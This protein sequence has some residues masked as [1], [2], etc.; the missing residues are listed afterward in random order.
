M[1]ETV[2]VL[3]LHLPGNKQLT[4]TKLSSFFLSVCPFVTL[5]KHPYCGFNAQ[6]GA[7][8]LLARGHVQYP[9]MCQPIQLSVRSRLSRGAPHCCFL[10]PYNIYMH[11][12]SLSFRSVAPSSDR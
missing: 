6:R 1:E 2:S 9:G 12:H 8:D 4:Q 11:P 10:P 5:L 3:P 7:T